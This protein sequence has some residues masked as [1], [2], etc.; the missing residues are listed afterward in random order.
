MG[1]CKL[2]LKEKMLIGKSHIIPYF[3]YKHYRFFSSSHTIKEYGV[4]PP[5]VPLPKAQWRKMNDGYYEPHILCDEC[6]KKIGKYEDYGK[7]LFIDAKHFGVR[8]MAKSKHFAVLEVKVDY[9]KY[10]L[11]I[12]S[13]I[14]KSIVCSLYQFSAITLPEE[15]QERLREMLF[16]GDEGSEEEFPIVTQRMIFPKNVVGDDLLVLPMY[17]GK[18]REFLTMTIG[19]WILTIYLEHTD[20][21]HTRATCL[22]KPGVLPLAFMSEELTVIVMDFYCNINQDKPIKNPFQ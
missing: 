17:R 20:E 8:P 21:Y 10:K 19:K 7:K 11:F 1:T 15:K 14:W 2:C 4:I 5:G 16:H 9:K 22:K 6:E 13:M 12:L 3:F 18:N